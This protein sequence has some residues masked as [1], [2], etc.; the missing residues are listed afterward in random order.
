MNAASALKAAA[1]R[2]GLSEDVA[3]AIEDLAA[4]AARENTVRAPAK[5][6]LARLKWET[7][8]KPDEDPAT[9]AWR[10]YAAEAAAGSLHRGVIYNEDR[11]L[12][13]RLNS[14]LRSIR[15]RRE[16]DIPTFP[17]WNTRQIA[18]GKAKRAPAR[19]PRTEGQRLY[20]VVVK[21]RRARPR[22]ATQ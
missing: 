5:P 16:F 8:R 12:H 14:W 18:A 15:C 13:R 20:D 4:N 21:R 19:P 3:K 1:V 6:R 17:D 7:H 2:Y 22:E 9:F 10:A 11:E